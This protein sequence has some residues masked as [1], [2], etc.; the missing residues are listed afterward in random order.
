[1]CNHRCIKTEKVTY[2]LQP[3]CPHFWY[4]STTPCKGNS[5]IMAC[6]CKGDNAEDWIKLSV[7]KVNFI[8]KVGCASRP[9][10]FSKQLAQG[11]AAIEALGL[12]EILNDA[13][14]RVSEEHE[15]SELC[16]GDHESAK[17]WKGS[18][19]THQS[20]S[21]LLAELHTPEGR[22]RIRKELEG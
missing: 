1:M 13:G 19:H 5:P 8:C 3:S 7:E 9:D 16:K 11:Q 17:Y 15:A 20:I 12:L 18:L 4:D 2:P 6:T 10:A 14:V 22:E 21:R